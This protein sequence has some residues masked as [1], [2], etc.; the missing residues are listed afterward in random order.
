MWFPEV[1]AFPCVRQVRPDAAYSLP[2]TA[3]SGGL[4]DVVGDGNR[5]DIRNAVEAANK[6]SPGWGKRAAHKY[7]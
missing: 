1:A 5:K 7:S 3:P 2:V 6:A 4:V